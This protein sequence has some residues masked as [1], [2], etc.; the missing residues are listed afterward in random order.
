MTRKSSWIFLRRW[1]RRVAEWPVR[2]IPLL[3]GEAQIAAQQLP[4]QNLLEYAHLKRAIIQRAGHN[5]EEQRQRFR[6]M[7]LVENGRLFVFAQQLHDA[8]R[9][10]LMQDGQ[11]TAQLVDAVVLEQ[12]ITSLPSR[13]SEW[14]QCHR[15][16]D[17]ETAI[18]LAE[19]YLVAKPRVGERTSSLSLFLPPLSLSPPVPRPRR[20]GPPTPA[21]RRRCTEADPLN[22][23]REAGPYLDGGVEPRSLAVPQTTTG[24]SPVQSVDP[25]GPGGIVRMSGPRYWHRG[26]ED[27]APKVYS[28]KEVSALIRVSATPIIAPGRDGLYRIPVSIKGGT[29]QALVNSGCNQTS[30]HQSLLQNSALDTSRTVRVRCVHGD[31]IHYPLTAIDIQFQ[32]KKHSV[33][34]AVNPHLKHPLILGT[35]WPGFNRLLRVLCAGVSWKNNLGISRCK[36]FPL[37]QSRDDTLKHA[38]ERVQVIDGKI[39]QPDRPLSYPYFAVIND[40]VYR[41]TQDTQTKENTTQLLVPKSRQEMLYQAAHSMAG[42]LGQAAT[43]NRLMTRFF[44]PGIHG[45]VSRWCAACS[46]CQ[47]VN[48]PATP[49]APLRP[50]PIMEIPF[51]RIGMDLTGPLEQSARGHRFALVLVDYATRYPEAV[52]LRNISAKSVAEAL[53][54]IISRVGIPKEIL[55]DQGTAFMS[56]TMREL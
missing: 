42:H 34:V 37:E 29:Y 24:L 35:N 30:I 45:D 44:W 46:E 38:L 33:E 13:T 12:F 53:F 19:D 20:R 41:V 5:L 16:N 8:C 49:K 26:H 55:T 54:R 47:L 48:P 6:S 14:V 9:R 52:A 31:V 7:E 50:L 51:E 21:P 43:L 11:T 18:R 4:A 2:V 23:P 36:D 25:A 56:R 40:R 1:L 10:W 27:S 3:S 22:V 39:L 32:G 28:V 17:L 15:P